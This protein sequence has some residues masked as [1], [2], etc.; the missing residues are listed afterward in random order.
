MEMR[1]LLGRLA[2][3]WR[4][5]VRFPATRIVI[6]V[7]SLFLVEVLALGVVGHLLKLGKDSPVNVLLALVAVT[8]GLTVYAWF[9][10][11]FERRTVVE[12]DRKGALQELVLGLFVGG[13]LF[14]T[15]MLVMWL[16]GVWTYT[17]LN[18][19]VS[20]VLPLVAGLAAGTIEELAMRGALF[21]I[22]EQSLGSWWALVIS[23]LVFGFLHSFNPG[24]TVVSSS[25][26][27]LEAGVMLAAA[28]M[29]TRRM[30]LVIGL[31]TAWNFTEGGIF[32][33]NVSGI[34]TEG[35]IGVK[36]QGSDLL[37]GGSFGPEAS[38]L[39]VAVCLV[40]GAGLIFLAVRKARVVQPYWKRA[41]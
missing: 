16:C 6:M 5:F 8:L 37:T 18:P 25:A 13:A 41:A 1:N 26:I 9:V 14:S 3:I 10:H 34:S 4:K 19:K 22:T 21:R 15:V 2:E 29:I 40:F 28:Y 32:K 35:L 11:R 33:T 7:V 31:H 36:F 17:G 27:A 30:W 39:S 38:I 12:L 23:A 20:L 24:A